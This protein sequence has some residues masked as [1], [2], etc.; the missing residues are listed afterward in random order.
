MTDAN[1]SLTQ[2]ELD[3]IKTQF[4]AIMENYPKVYAQF[5]MTPDLPSAREARNKIDA[6]LASLHNR[7]F[8]F[9]A[10][11][12]KKQDENEETMDQLAK[13]GA[14]LNAILARKTATLNNKDQIMST[15]PLTARSDTR[16]TVMEPFI[17]MSGLSGLSTQLPGC[18][19]NASGN[20]T[21]CPC[22]KIDEKVCAE[23][24]DNMDDKT[25]KCPP[26]IANRSLVVE[27][28]TM[29]KRAYIYAVCRIIY[30]LIG[31][32]IIGYFTFNMVNAPDST[33]LYDARAKAEQLKTG[34]TNTTNDAINR[35]RNAGNA[36]AINAGMQ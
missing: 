27:A 14:R 29:E 5:K 22:V 31:T 19:L 23:A 10:A 13:K 24:C 1:P 11:M 34:L 33:I 26:S 16:V 7:M 32:C 6:A 18:S 21:N 8:I 12:E 2:R 9:K 30:L 17:S 28:A 20:P 35:V 3:D 36:N 4:H 25:K 15:T